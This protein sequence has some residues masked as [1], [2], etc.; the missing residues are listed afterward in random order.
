MRPRLSVLRRPIAV[1]TA[2]GLASTTGAETLTYGVDVGVAE[3]DNVTL[4]P[5]DKVSQTMATADVDFDVKQQTRLL[6]L[7]AKGN[8]SDL[9][10]LQG[11]YGN[12]LLGRFDGVARIALIPQRLTWVF[13]DDFGQSALDPFTPTVPTNLEN[14]NYF[15]T[16]PDLSLRLGGTSF[17]NATARVARVQYETS[18]FN[19]DRLLGS[20]AWGLH[21]SAN[22]SISL[23]GET[24][25]VLFENTVLNTDYDH[26]S[27]FVRYE[28]QGART[29]LSAD[30]GATN[31]REND[32][33]TD[34]GLAKIQLSRKISPAA[35][36]TLSLGHDLTDASTSFSGLQSGA[37]G[38]VGS[39]PAAVTS[40]SYT[41]NYA[42]L[43]WQYQRNRTT[44]GIS[45]RW[46]KDTY[47]GAPQFDYTRGGAEF[48][49]ERKLTHALTA[50]LIG[51]L[52]KT[53]YVNAVV[54]SQ[55]GSTDYVNGLA[56]ATVTGENGSSDYEDGIVGAVLSWRPGR[57]LELRL[58]CEH[59]SHDATG[60]NTSYRENRVFLTIGYRPR[61][62]VPDNS[63]EPI[64]TD[65]GA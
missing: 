63:P 6:D 22:S 62:L 14:V 57:A 35:K 52:Y 9:D 5:T 45:G 54:S 2:L 58:R 1:I 30:L 4:S 44:I 48:S 36:L 16:G 51:R 28:L 60:V 38:V 27:A 61:V 56:P 42:S 65:P 12:Q 29:D 15:T 33:S 21:L 20:L 53:D 47:A 37:I 55:N 11:A 24:E 10:Y 8:F 23:N 40:T 34:G 49:V 25:R 13:Q 41:T 7:D 31:V 64:N 59:S 43:G 19:S 18:P 26:S 50:Q 17:L 46:E 39:A 32:T 3:T